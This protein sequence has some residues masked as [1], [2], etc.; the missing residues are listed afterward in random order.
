MSFDNDDV[1]SEYPL[2]LNNLPKYKRWNK[3]RRIESIPTLV[4][5]SKEKRKKKSRRKEKPESN[6]QYNFLFQSIKSI[7]TCLR[8][9]LIFFLPK[10]IIKI[11]VGTGDF[12]FI[13]HPRD[14]NDIPRM[15][16]FGKYLPEKFVKL[17]FRF[18][19]PFITSR[20]IRVDP[21]TNKI[22]KG[23]LL[24]SP[25]WAEQMMRNTK[26]ARQ[27][28]I[29]TVQLAEKLGCKVAG[30]G[31]FTSIVTHDGN[32]IIG[33]TSIGITTG[34]P[35]SAAVAVANLIHA[36]SLVGKSIETS[37]IAIIGSA[38]SVGTGC[39]RVL[40]EHV[41][42]L[43]LIDINEPALFKLYTELK[44]TVKEKKLD[45]LI[46][47]SKDLSQVC[48]CDG[49]IVVTNA[50]KAIVEDK[51]LKKGAIVIDSAQPKNVSH[52]VPK[53]RKDVLVIESA[54]VQIDGLICNSDLDV[55]KNE[56]LGCMTESLLLS[57]LKEKKMALGKVSS[58]EMKD[59]YNIAVDLGIN[60]AYFRN[61]NG[62]ITEQDI[63]N[64]K[65][66]IDA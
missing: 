44:N 51:H 15:F 1:K 29:K 36:I 60:L 45:T 50:I 48:E 16:P 30:L 35:F 37:K 49:V 31:A 66:A 64:L 17:W 6:I 62:F 28:V 10:W 2:K 24:I 65:E 58:E 40:A 47:M 8:D 27:K 5:T 56:A 26:L 57:T 9:G 39:S 14:F 22:I 53:L 32:D 21:K 46:T 33:K 54:I 7:V 23:W 42:E 61:S 34:N 55:N 12:A 41:K 18:Q 43:H 4:K 19:W 11:L 38:G 20:I 3:S 13:A 25:L 59:I 52:T 63:L